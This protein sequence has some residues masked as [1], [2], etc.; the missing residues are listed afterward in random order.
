[1]SELG[2]RLIDRLANLDE[3]IL[4]LP[5]VEPALDSAAGAPW[6]VAPDSAPSLMLSSSR[7]LDAR[8]PGPILGPGARYR[9]VEVHDGVVGIDVMLADGA[10]ARGYGN[11]IDMRSLDS[12]FSATGG[13]RGRGTS[14]LA[15]AGLSRVTQSLASVTG[16]LRG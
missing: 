1:M 7:L 4:P 11:A 9:V 14:T 3:P 6:R 13:T 10:A 5:A 2:T 8:H 16:Q 15:R 12:R